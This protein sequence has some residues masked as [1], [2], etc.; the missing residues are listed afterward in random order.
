[1]KEGMSSLDI[2]V[3]TVELDRF[4]K[5]F[6]ID[7]IYQLN[8]RTILL[9]LR[10]REGN[11][12]NLICEAGKRAHITSYA[13]EKPL[14]PPAFCMALRKYLRNGKMEKVQ[15]H[16]FERIVE[17]MLSN[18]GEE[19]RL[20]IE[21]FGEG[22]IILV[23]PE[24]KIL[25]A[26]SYRRMRD[27]NILR[28][29]V[30]AYPPSRSDDPRGLQRED[31][32][33]IRSLG[34]LEVVRAVA[35][36][37]GIGGTYSEEI[38][39]RAGI[40]KNTPCSS[41]EDRDLGA[42]FD[43]LQQ[44]L[45]EA[46]AE[47]AKPFGF[48]DEEGQW[49]DVAPVP[50]KRYSHL[51]R[52]QY[53]T[54]NEAL[55][56]YYTKMSFGERVSHVKDL[57]EQEVARL[58]RILRDQEETLNELRRKAEVYRKI[59]DL[60][61]RHLSELQL[62]LQSIMGV[63]RS[64]R[65]WKEIEEILQKEKR[66]SL[67]PSVYF[68][69]LKPKP[70]QVHV[71]VEGVVLDLDLRLP[72]QKNGADY[73]KE[74]KKAERKIE[75]AEKAVMETRAKIEAARL[76]ALEKVEETVKPPSKTKLE[77]YEKFRWFHSSNGF[78]VVGGRDASTNEVLIKRYMEPHDV[79]FHADL[80]GAPFVL[81]KTRGEKPPEQTF[82]EAARFAAS[83]SRAWKQGLAATDVYS[84]SPQQVSRTPP[85]GEYLP[86]GSFMI[87]GSRNNWKGMPLEVAV[88]VE[89]EGGQSRV[90]GGPPEAI[91][92]KTKLLVRLIPGREPSARLAKQIRNRL[93][94]LALEEERKA[95]VRIPLEEIQKFIPGG[96][97][98]IK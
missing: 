80:P 9:K 88:G 69:A 49:I 95:I 51:K 75:G 76:K 6:R 35:R 11:E 96:G 94:Q 70:L 93:A 26:T 64:G 36:F 62:L 54:F 58:E 68:E 28:G 8:P 38:L 98:A 32:Q 1:L 50:L 14:K 41:L 19:Y 16:G 56:E 66:E 79:V 12:K 17:I 53:Q 72:A 65:S 91:A 84:V 44:L 25:H 27:R 47:N 39:L 85:S 89:M 59:G 83:Y 10:S 2:A 77:W 33:K 87:Y 57:V 24:G 46:S 5:G 13:Y 55:D 81:V 63:K 52:V 90:V 21:L 22:N 43:S 4:L 78:L 71:A 67:V 97:G 74:A 86:R 23:N 42:I 48:I 31:F 60:I 20:V 34:R 61:Y 29:E 92:N 30:Y 37:L 7:N 82:K 45:S 3:A 73:Y 18:R 40:S 15:Q